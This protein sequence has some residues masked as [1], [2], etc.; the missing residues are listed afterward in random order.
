[1]RYGFVRVAS[2][3]GPVSVGSVQHNTTT[4]LQMAKK[5]D[6]EG[7]ELLVFPELCLT[8][9]TCGDLFGQTLLLEQAEAALVEIAKATERMHMVM[10]VGLPLRVDHLLLNVGAVVGGGHVCGIVP[11]TY[12]PNYKEFY[13][14]RWFSSSQQLHRDL[15]TIAGEQVPI[16]ADLLFEANGY[17]FGV[18]L[19]EDL[20][21]PIPPSCHLALGGAD[22]ICNLSAS[23]ELI[24]KHAYLRSL[25]AGQSARC[26]CGYVYAGAGWGESSQDLVYGGNAL[27]Y[28]NGILLEASDRFSL[29]AQLVLSEID[30]ERL[31]N[32]RRVNTTF[33]T[34]PHAADLRCVRLSMSAKGREDDVRFIRQVDPHP[35]V[36]GGELLRAR[37]EEIFAIQ[38][39]GLAKRMAHTRASTLVVGVSGGLDSTLALLV[40]TYVCDKLQLPR[41]SV[42]GVTMPGF[43][44]TGRTHT[45]AVNLIKQLGATLRE[46]PI[47]EAASLHLKAIGHEEGVMDVTYENAQARE[48]TQ[49]L[50]DLANQLGGLVV[51]TGDMSELALGWA[52]YNG[53]HMSSYGVNVGVPKTLVRYLVEWVA[54][55]SEEATRATL[56]DICDTPVSPELLPADE[57]GD[58]SQKT[59]DLVGPYELHDFFLYYF[60]R[61]GFSPKKILFLALQAFCHPQPEGERPVSAPSEGSQGE[62]PWH[63]IL[64]TGR[65]DE[66]TIR[67]WLQVFCHRFFSQ[68]F[69]RSCLPDGP[70][71]G[72]VCLS[73]R[74][75][76]RMP[77]DAVSSSWEED[78][79]EEEEKDSE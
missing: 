54:S 19:C 26:L 23:N 53:D 31:R 38:T 35:F 49:V 43:G 61:H 67:H 63:T 71:V 58:I 42:V 28:E 78:C 4:L 3:I 60:L 75:D 74:G 56:L 52:T 36:P 20:W 22:I 48:R 29:S 76:W 6:E 69:K 27:L 8:G 50:F 25:I 30:V 32:E 62:G 13:E 47:G 2:A 17:T 15:V 5:A 65:Y 46:I 41:T 18:E 37:C 24:S 57:K 39:A 1:M 70:K 51:G 45:N 77:S 21:A 66:P 40:S 16:G 14:A 79:F 7:I 55:V 12:L 10:V 59:E 9:Y 72:S 73:P 64:R 34:D 33:R 44:T 11:K 68:Q